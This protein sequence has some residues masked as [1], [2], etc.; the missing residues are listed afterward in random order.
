MSH[1]EE[2]QLAIDRLDRLEAI[3]KITRKRNTAIKL[4]LFPAFAIAL[5]M[6]AMNFGSAIQPEPSAKF[7]SATAEELILVDSKG[8]QRAFFGID[9]SSAAGAR[10]GLFIKDEDGNVRIILS[11][12]KD[13]GARV[14]VGEKAM[15][16]QAVLAIT[17]EGAGVFSMNDKS[18][19]TRVILSVDDPKRSQGLHLLDKEG[20]RRAVFAIDPKGDVGITFNDKKERARATLGLDA[21]GNPHLSLI[22]NKGG[23]IFSKP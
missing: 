15:K 16:Q 5:V 4:T 6:A 1:S 9:K 13:Q 2:M 17:S 11:A 19:T 20:S 10:S 3:N 8:R 7:Q 14:A 12:S 18:G 21:E 23:T 22:D